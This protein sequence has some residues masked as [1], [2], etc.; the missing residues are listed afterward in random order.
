MDYV[1]NNALH[2][3][4]NSIQRCVLFYDL[5]CKYRVYLRRRFKESKGLD[6]PEFE[7][8]ME[9]VGMWHIYSHISTCYPR[10]TPLYI[11]RI[12]MVDGE[13]IE[14]LWSRLNLISPSCRTMSL[15]NRAETLNSHMNDSNWK[16]NIEMGNIS[17]RFCSVDGLTSDSFLQSPRWFENGKK[18][19]RRSL[20]EQ[21]T[22]QTSTYLS[23]LKI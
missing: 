3:K 8:W 1:L 2:Y 23:H 18:M 13:V 22:W 10:F 21:M 6:F 11:P 15:S 16:K 20:N 14:T 17:L 4:M 7:E 9:G 19:K 12:G 5:V